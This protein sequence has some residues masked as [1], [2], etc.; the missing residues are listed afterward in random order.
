M[1]LN[2]KNGISLVVLI[3]TIVM[4]IILAGAVIVSIISNNPISEAKKVEFKSDLTSFANELNTYNSNQIM[5]G[6]KGYTPS[7]LNADV[8][9]VTYDGI[10]D[11]NKTINN[12]IPLL[13]SKS[14]YDGLFEVVEGKLVFLGTD[15]TQCELAEEIGIEVVIIGEPK[16][17]I[18]A[19]SETVVQPGTAVIYTIE[20]SSSNAGLT[21]ID[22][23]GNIEVIYSN[24]SVLTTQPTLEGWDSISGLPSDYTRSAT[25]TIPTTDLDGIYKLRIKAGSVTN[26][27][28]ISNTKDTTSLTNFNVDN[29]APS[30]PGMVA[31]PTGW[32]NGNVAVT[33]TFSPDS[34]TRQ[35]ST[36]GT[37][38][39]NYT[40]PVIVNT[41]STTVYAKAIDTAG[42]QNIQSTL[43]VANID[44][45]L[46]TLLFG[47]NGGSGSTASTTVAVSDTG[48]SDINTSTLQYVWDT[49]NISTPGSGWAAFANGAT[50]TNSIDGTYYLW[51]KASDNAGNILTT[52]SNSFVVNTL[53]YTLAN[54]AISE[55]SSV[56]STLTVNS[57]I[58][59]QLP[60]YNN[61]IIPAGFGAINTVDASWSNVGTDWDKGLVIQDVSGNQF[62][63][64]PIN[65]TTVTYAKWCVTGIAYNSASLL[66]DTLP[67]EFNTTN[68][69]T[70]YK[71]FYIARYE[72]MFDYN[73]GTL[74]AAS[75]KSINKA[76]TNWSGSRNA[77]Y[78]GYL[79]NFSSYAEAKTYSENMASRYGYDITK[80]ITNLITGAEWDT[81][82]KWIQNSG[83]SVTDS[84]AWGNYSDSI[85]PA[86][87]AGYAS[88]QISGYSEYWKTKNIY[89]IAGNEWEWTNE[90]YTT[91]RV[92]RSGP[93][94]DS[95]SGYSAAYRGLLAPTTNNDDGLG[96]RAALFIL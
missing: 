34:T 30:N 38:W 7:K 82:M 66:D 73:G 33:I 31:S 48:G 61:P 67:A 44:K 39:S 69:T 6:I 54:V 88:I 50:I 89:D 76:T 36:N 60:S 71:G 2:I 91:Y 75:K 45:V 70:T 72:S 43:T 15:T 53:P 23:D 13:E 58:T 94:L 3:I 22:L 84:R 87:I 85:A 95:G 68:I 41:N 59:G 93:Y 80:V 96:F 63:W 55:P 24:G 14:K 19:A 81:I 4:I 51:V 42:N 90:A 20:F 11:T 32:T 62:V 25:I 74:R 64:I 18:T 16:I 57:T 27:N 78:S 26:E 37:D 29:T 52:K 9:S 77:S 46:P 47:T 92:L 65:G 86:N 28:G 10:E 49:Q 12:I 1:K 40:I 8:D 35:F 17:T 56:T 21:T 5:D 79:W 83:K